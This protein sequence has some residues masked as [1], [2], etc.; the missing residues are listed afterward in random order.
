MTGLDEA[1][2][3]G[4]AEGQEKPLPPKGMSCLVHCPVAAMGSKK[5]FV[6]KGRAIVVDDNPKKL[7][8]FQA[9]L[10]VA[11]HEV[12]PEK[13]HLGPIQVTMI[14]WLP[15]PKG[16]YGTGKNAGKLKGSA[17]GR[18]ITKPDVDKVQRAIL[19]VGTGLWFKDD[20]QVV[21]ARVMKQYVAEGEEE[22][23]WIEAKCL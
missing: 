8:S 13:I 6:V 14:F 16:H 12:K 11:M 19:D 23:V 10:R 9:E 22:R 15:R 3:D 2:R 1:F 7:R 21:D 17:P 18:P 20:S 4:W 5:G